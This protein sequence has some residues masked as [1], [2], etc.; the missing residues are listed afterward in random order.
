MTPLQQVAADVSVLASS[1]EM[2]SGHLLGAL[3]ASL[4]GSVFAAATSALGALPATRVAALATE[5]QGARRSAL[6]RYLRDPTRVLSHF[7]VGRVIC[8]ALTAVLIGSGVHPIAPSWAIPVAVFGT[9]A[10]YGLLTEV[11]TF[12]ARRDLDRN[13]VALLRILR[14]LEVII[15]PVAWPLTVAAKL[16]ARWLPARPSADVR[17]TEHE[18]ELLLAEGQRTGRLRADHALMIQRVLEFNELTAAQV[19]VPRTSLIAIDCNTSIEEVLQIIATQGHSRYPVYCESVDNIVGLLYAKDLFRI[20]NEPGVRSARVERFVRSPVNFVPEAQSATALLREM[21][22]RRLHMAV[23]VD[24]Y[25]GV[26]GIVT[27][28]DIIE[29]IIGDIQDEHDVEREPIVDLGDGSVLADA[30]VPVNDLSDFLGTDIPEAGD[31]VSLGGLLIHWAGRVPDAGSE[32]Q[33]HG[34]KFIVRE[35]DE[36]RVS[37]VEIRPIQAGP[38]TP[39]PNDERSSPLPTLSQS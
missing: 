5:A 6:E 12:L 25:G 14:P 16:T 33:A 39:K 24:D 3:F 27:L 7:L 36:R 19:M 17:T 18:V 1:R 2:M 10:T 31:F 9:L 20:L 22:A 28:E 23:V 8:T 4:L 29:E 11:A 13:A 15:T 35:A 37:K 30:A 38:E 32:V 26:S 34:F 21:R